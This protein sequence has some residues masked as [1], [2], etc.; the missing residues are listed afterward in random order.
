MPIDNEKLKTHIDAIRTHLS[1]ALSAAQ[2]AQAEIQTIEGDSDLFR[3]FAF[4]LVPNLNEWVNGLQAG[5]VKDLQSV[6]EQRLPKP[7]VL[8]NK[9]K[10]R[11]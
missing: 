9:K 7:E 5:N 11:K 6:L 3:K 8:K 10:K 1:N 2:Q 4:Y